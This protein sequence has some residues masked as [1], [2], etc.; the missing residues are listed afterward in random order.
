M[1][2]WLRYRKSSNL[3]ADEKFIISSQEEWLKL[4]YN[5]NL[6]SSVLWPDANLFSLDI[7][8]KRRRHPH[9]INYENNEDRNASYLNGC[10][11]LAYRLEHNFSGSRCLIYAPLR[12]ALPIW[13]GIS[14]FIHNIDT[15]VYYPVTSSFIAYPV[16]FRIQ[17]NKNGV[18]SGR[19]N[20]KLELERLRPHLADFSHFIYVALV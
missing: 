20:N 10:R 19:F 8:H 7:A 4:I 14:Q 13:R 5:P 11:K 6:I 16:E 1:E 18:T 3:E 9:E 2:L 15:V 17:G 12:G